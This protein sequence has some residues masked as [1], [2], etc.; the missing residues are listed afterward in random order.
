MNICFHSP[1]GLGGRMVAPP[2][3]SI[4]H[5]ALML[6]GLASGTSRIGNPL[7]TGDC[8]STR[9][10]LERLGVG[11]REI[12]TC[13]G[14]FGLQI[15]GCGLRGL[16]EPQDLL[17]AG[18]SGTTA[19][20]LSG[21]LAGRR[22]FTVL[23]GD[24]S[25]RARPMLRV[26]QPLRAMG[27]AIDGREH[28]RYLPLVFAS[29][30][31]PLLSADIELEVA[32]AQVKSALMF[33]ALRAES[34]VRLGGALAS[35]D[36]TERIFDHLGLPM[37][38]RHG[39][40]NVD[41]VEE[42]PAFQIDVPGDLSSAA[43]FLTA[44]LISGGQLTVEQC[45]LNPTR[46]G[47]VHVLQRM[48]AEIRLEQCGSSG[49][50]PSGRLHVSPATLRGVEIG[51]DMIPS[52][53]DEIP[54]LAVVGCFAN[55]ATIVRGAGELRL[56][57]SDRLAAVARLLKSVGGAIELSEDGFTV[58]GPQSLYAGRVDPGGDHRIAMAAAVL[59]AAIPE[60]VAVSGFECAEVSFPDFL[61]TFRAL[62][63]EVS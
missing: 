29:D 18:N 33:A 59:G 34:T 56:K 47:F 2:D 24:D 4:T 17:D 11:I 6:A 36:H 22:M 60:G 8:I 23:S 48:G 1:R 43:F 35:R 30:S 38:W 57:E 21:I 3:K 50:E 31:G 55:G 13:E 19:R 9:R 7:N 10:C 42:V 32:S 27:A 20:L 54:L 58:E 28:G 62:G 52:C 39:R 41:P 40:L 25:L 49:G 12:E 16:R 14:S 51:G 26:V 5:R 44:A 53:I 61:A 37:W 63:G 45:G 15:E 46:L